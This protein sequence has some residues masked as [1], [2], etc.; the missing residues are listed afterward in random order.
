MSSEGNE[1][2][3]TFS[4]SK[5]A[6]T[7]VITTS[8][9]SQA[10]LKDLI[11]MLLRMYKKLKNKA[12]FCIKMETHQISL[13]ARSAV[14]HP[15]LVLVGLQVWRASLG[16]LAVSQNWLHNA[17]KFEDQLKMLQI[18]GWQNVRVKCHT[19]Y[20]SASKS[21]RHFCNL[22]WKC[23]DVFHGMKSTWA[24]SL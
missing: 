16:S 9:T 19:W 24:H 13:S 12:T 20:I 7:S 8:L 14:L 1:G 3:W 6:S 2:K 22:K 18:A 17:P 5:Y 4:Y 10:K 23:E 21:K 15:E 11:T